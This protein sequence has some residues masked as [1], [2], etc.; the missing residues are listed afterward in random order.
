M[1]S[2]LLCAVL[3]FALAC[4]VFVS[5]SESGAHPAPVV[6]EARTDALSI[7]TTNPKLIGV[8]WD[9]AAFTPE[10]MAPLRPNL[11]R[12]DAGFERLYPTRDDGLNTD[13]F[14]ALVA[15]VDE[16]LAIG[17]EPVVILSYMPVW[18]ADKDRPSSD[19]TKVPPEDPAEWERLVADVVELL[20]ALGVRW[21]EVWN[22]PD[23]PVFFQGLLTE[24]LER[25]YRPSAEAVAD[26]DANSG[27]DLRFGGCACVTADPAWIVPMMAFARDNGLPLDFLSWHHYG[28]APFLGPDGAEPLGP[29][30]IEP[31]L[32]PLR[33]ENP[34]TSA[35]T[36]GDQVAA[37]R[38][39]RDA[40]YA[41]GEAKPE[42]WIDEWNL[43]P[44]GFDHRHD[45]V[46]GAAFQT[47]S[48]IEFQRAGLDRASVFRS[49]D[50]A[51]G[52]DVVAAQPELYG[53]WGLVGRY[54]TVKPAWRAH[55]FWR[56]LGGDVL[57]FTSPA[58]ARLGVSAVL[59]RRSTRRFVALIANFQASGE[60]AHQL[61]LR[62]ED[63]QNRRWSVRLF[64]LNGSR[65]RF[66][67][68]SSSGVLVVP[69]ELA[70]NTGALME[71]RAR[72]GSQ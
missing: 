34:T 19:R 52:P 16:A 58:D 65:R 17:G 32:A 27:H 9:R 30:E 48:L 55:R 10:V 53:A 26:V 63:E 45:S 66:D 57:A 40:I 28:N 8:G 67:A 69:L 59:T 24:F 43:S 11:V 64:G 21:F 20:V 1:R 41:D 2:R 36:Y 61:E 46:V 6:L 12:I 51:Y 56:E 54:G 25:V 22:E 3:C 23:N 49:V 44:G 50:P 39:W 13:A 4:G 31:L 71:L 14:D 47:A 33:R 70:P 37:V 35:S 62:L 7:A 42:L 18:L 60:H 29:P 72:G 5:G 15:E 68:T 38:A